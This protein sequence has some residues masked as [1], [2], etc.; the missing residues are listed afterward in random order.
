MPVLLA[1]FVVIFVVADIL[2]RRYIRSKEEKQ[3]KLNREQDL[4]RGLKLDHSWESA[5]LKRVEIENP[6]ARVICAAE[7]NFLDPFRKSLVLDGYSVDTVDKSSEVLQLIQS[8]NYELVFLDPKLFAGDGVE[9][10]RAVK[11]S[12]PDVDLIILNGTQSIG[13]EKNRGS[14]TPRG[15]VDLVLLNGGSMGKA[16]REG[17]HPKGT[18]FIDKNANE[19]ELLAA[20]NWI[21]ARRTD[22]I[23]RELTPTVHITQLERVSS[24]I[25]TEFVIPGGVFISPGHSWIHIEEDGNA[26]V[27]MDDFSRKILGR[28]DRIEFPNI[29]RTIKKG[30]PLFRVR[31]GHRTLTFPSPLSGRVKR[32]NALLPD[33]LESLATNPYGSNWVCTIEADRLAS[34]I[35]DWKIGQAAV[36]FILTEIEILESNLQ[37]LNSTSP[38]GKSRIYRGCLSEMNDQVWGQVEG[39]IF[40]RTIK[41]PGVEAAAVAEN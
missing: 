13:E 40:T 11:S 22:R 12:R 6:K 28:I 25:Q 41:T 10:S 26:T 1:A 2:I 35:L 27:G 7:N 38:N 34:E 19:K 33:D 37:E 8:N 23:R 20:V 9:I 5:S 32:N 15:N 39:L 29:G 30:Q 21:Q 3:R 17:V 36:D 14:K 31:Q 16:V 24:K 4:I 18:N